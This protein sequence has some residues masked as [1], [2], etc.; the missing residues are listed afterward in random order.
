MTGG[1]YFWSADQLVVLGMRPDPEPD[2]SIR[3][4][5]AKGAMMNADA[6]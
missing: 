6:S 5:G 1:S 3:G 2:D 4:L